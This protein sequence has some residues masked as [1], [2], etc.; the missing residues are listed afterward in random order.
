MK[1][2]ETDIEGV[3]I[4]EPKVYG[5][6]RGFFLESYHAEK[7]REEG[8]IDVT[9]VQDNH[10][11][12]NKGILRGLHAQLANPQDKLVR[13]I[14]GEVFDVVVDVRRGS[15][16]YGQHVAVTLSAENF[17]QLFIPKGFIHGFLVTSETAE[18]EYKC[19]SFYDPTSEISVLWNDPDLG[20]EWPI[21][22]P[23]LSPKDAEAGRLRDFTKEFPRD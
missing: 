6:E 16:T 21:D 18:F 22:D 3:I 15:K 8:G 4:I 17:R 5:D 20:I 10:S 1:F 14:Q 23:K 12:S 13:V 7:Y 9:F 19:S 2:V 11:R